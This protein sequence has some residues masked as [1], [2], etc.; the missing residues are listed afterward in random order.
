MV[1]DLLMKYRWLSESWMRVEQPA[2]LTPETMALFHDAEYIAHLQKAND[3]V[4]EPK[5]IEFN[6]GTAENPIINGLFDYAALSAGAS[7]R[8]MEL[9]LN[10]EVETV[11][12][13]SGGMHHAA[14][15][16]ADGFCYIN[17]CGIVIE[18]LM[19]EGKR[20]V[21]IDIDAHHGNGI[22]DAFYRE[23]RVLKISIHESGETL[24]PWGGYDKEIGGGK[25]R[26]YNV[27]VPLP[28]ET[29][30]VLYIKTFDAIVPPLV[31]AFDPDIVVSV[32]GIDTVAADPLTHL[33]LTNNGFLD[34]V[35]RIRD[36][37][38]PLLAL[39][40]GGYNMDSLARSWALA[41]AVLNHIEPQDDYAGAVA[42]IFLGQQ[43]L[44]GAN[45]RDMRQFTSGPKKTENEDKVGRVIEFL[46]ENIFPV[47]GIA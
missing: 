46:R 4:F 35:T 41:W 43:E 1:Y 37:G 36:F 7:Y 28:P 23:P 30:D 33:S 9:L 25:G 34:A 13:P 11:F 10:G 31:R 6:L 39:G 27:N 47:H 29:D 18:R 3:G 2:L 21:Y 22:Q 8:G 14:R 44:E 12:S 26:G 40:G 15:R 24:Y 42:G 32:I 17:D 38:K 16:H 20:V 45:L 19:A 5:M